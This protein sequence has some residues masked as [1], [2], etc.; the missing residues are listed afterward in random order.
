MS[1]N[2]TTSNAT[3]NIDVEQERAA[4]MIEALDIDLP[5]LPPD[6]VPDLTLE[7]A[8]LQENKDKPIDYDEILIQED[9]VERMALDEAICLPKN[10]T[11]E[12]ILAAIGELISIYE[13]ERHCKTPLY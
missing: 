2:S 1:F 5:I 6:L 12:P 4:A 7:M 9:K 10:A 8:R 3:K 11:I 13:M